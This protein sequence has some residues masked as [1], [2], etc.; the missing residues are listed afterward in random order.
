MQRLGDWLRARSATAVSLAGS[1]PSILHAIH[2]SSMAP[3]GDKASNGSELPR[4]MLG[5]LAS[6]A[7]IGVLAAID[8]ACAPAASFA[9][10]YLLVVALAAWWSSRRTAILVV[11]LSSPAILLHAIRRSPGPSLA[12]PAGWDLA[13]EIG[14]LLCAAVLVSAVRGLTANLEQRVR[15][16]TTALEREIGDRRQ[17][18]ERLQKTMQQFRQLA[19]HISDAF[20]MREAGQTTMVY[21]SPAYELIWGCSCRTVYQSPSAWLEAIHPEDRERVAHAIATQQATGAYQQEYRITRPD[22]ELRWI[23]D[24]AFPIRDQT[25]KVTRIVGIA[26]DITERHRLEREILEISDREQARLGQ[27]LHDSLC[28][29][30][31]S[32]AFDNNALKKRL[33]ARAV[34]EAAAAQ[35][36]SAVL[37]D[38]IT[39]A[40]TLARGLFPVQLET[41]GLRVALQQLAANVSARF[42]V[43]CHVQCPLPVN[44]R[45]NTVATHLYR[46]AQEATTNA[47]KH[48]QARS[49][50]IRLQAQAE[51]IDLEVSDDGIGIRLPAAQGSGLGL[52]IM[53]YRART[54][55][56]TLKVQRGPDGGT[57]VSCR[58]PQQTT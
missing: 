33:T 19:E 46:I 10:F 34:P 16:R 7:L 45:D 5:G 12:W 2:D 42:N 4:G 17:T 55:G 43:N 58:A 27:D 9:P 18:E 48:G 41:D 50:R 14:I 51:H 53:E 49:I 57:T 36:I 32:I 8:C 3:A 47:V 1:L 22:G 37:N 52:H 25:G 24:R 26:E 44:V 15:E 39:E 11:A 31:V 40:R 23:R 29:K 30:L 56:G 35:Q 38:A 54:I 21:V 20:W 28:Q 6:L 13:V